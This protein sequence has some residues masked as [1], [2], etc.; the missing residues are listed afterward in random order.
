[1]TAIVTSNVGHLAAAGAVAIINWR[2]ARGA[3]Q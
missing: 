1:M 3:N 2:V